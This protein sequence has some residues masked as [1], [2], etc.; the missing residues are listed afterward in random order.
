VFE[1]YTNC[2][3]RGDISRA[4]QIFCKIHDYGFSVI[5]ILD[6]YFMFIKMTDVLTEEEK[7]KTIP[8]MCKFITAFHN[9]HEDSIELYFFTNNLVRELNPGA[10][11][12]KPT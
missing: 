8:V 12:V 9:I 4:I 5:D 7:Y 6:D 3:K 1:E 10:H 2:V 11:G